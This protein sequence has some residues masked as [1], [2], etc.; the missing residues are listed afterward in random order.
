MFS[1]YESDR[2]YW[3]NNSLSCFYD[4]KIPVQSDSLAVVS[5]LL[6]YGMPL[7]ILPSYKDSACKHLNR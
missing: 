7:D 1:K 2:N 6:S 3:S 5:T 4:S